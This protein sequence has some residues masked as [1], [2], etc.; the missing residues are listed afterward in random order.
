MKHETKVIQKKKAFDLKHG[1]PIPKK[2]SKYRVDDSFLFMEIFFLVIIMTQAHDAME[3]SLQ[4]IY[5]KLWTR[6]TMTLLPPAW[7]ILVNVKNATCEPSILVDAVS[8]IFSVTKPYLNPLV[9]LNLKKSLRD[10]YKK[11]GKI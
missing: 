2:I 1:I 4:M 6:L 11:R 5:Q 7:R 8:I 9:H 3:T 10:R